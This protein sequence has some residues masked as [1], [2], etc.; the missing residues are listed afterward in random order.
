VVST[1]ETRERI[2][3]RERRPRHSRLGEILLDSGAVTPNQLEHALAQQQAL[4]LSIGQTLVRLNYVSDE[5]VR[6]ALATQLN[7]PYVDLERMEIDRGLAR[8]ITASFAKRHALL[9]IATV[10]RTLT[11]AMDDPTV[12]SVVQDLQRMTGLRV[13]VVTAAGPAIR[14]AFNQLYGEPLSHAAKP[15]RM[16]RRSTDREPPPEAVRPRVETST[17]PTSSAR[18]DELFGHL[19]WQAIESQCSDIHLEMLPDKLQVRFRIDGV[20]RRQSL[21]QLGSQINLQMREVASRIKILS[22]LDIAE[23]RRPQDGSFQ[24]AVD[25]NGAKLKVDL[26]VSV[27]PTYFG[28]SIVIRLLDR[29]RAPRSIDE[30]NLSPHVA[31]RVSLLL[32]RTAGVF[33]VTGPTGSGKSTTLY[34]CLMKL[35]R[36]DIRVLTAEDPV[37][38]VY[39]ELSQSEVNEQI[40]NTFATYL[41]AFLRHDPEVMMVGEIR[42]QETAQMVFRAAQ[43]GHLL[44]STLHTTSAIQALARLR[45]LTIESTSISSS[46][47]GAMSQRLVRRVCPMCRTEDQPPAELVSQFFSV[48]PATMKFYRGEGCEA[49]GQTGYRGRLI[50]ADLWIPDEEDLSLIARQ[51]SFDLIKESARRTTLTM[52]HDAWL[53]LQAG[54]TTLEELLRVLPYQAVEELRTQFSA[55]PVRD[56]D[57]AVGA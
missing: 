7:I 27:I 16:N 35:H 18:A 54:L 21:G 6:Q 52:A 38:Y 33:L 44:L 2:A 4:R 51:A 34:A 17:L 46:L 12:T 26:R 55:S 36:P 57:V 9:P 25:R 28:E 39:E 11:V 41:R 15:V 42:D 30:L 20:L 37:E 1:P 32:Q 43:T 23:R 19:L 24:I 14:E 10:D 40:G 22:K 49:C 31:R 47:I 3:A 53:R 8:I 13:T 50:L 48:V 45:D 5:T 56:D 29:A